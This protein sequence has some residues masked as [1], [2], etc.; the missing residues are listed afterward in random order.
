MCLFVQTKKAAWGLYVISSC[1]SCN[2]AVRFFCC[3]PW[4]TVYR[5]NNCVLFVLLTRSVNFQK[6]WR[7]FS[8]VVKAVIYGDPPHGG[9]FLRVLNWISRDVILSPTTW[10]AASCR[11]SSLQSG[12]TATC[13]VASYK[14]DVWKMDGVSLC[15]LWLKVNLE[16]YLFY[17][18]NCTFILQNCSKHRLSKVLHKIKC[19]K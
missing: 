9:T 11:L 13:G 14:I 10:T 19:N 12:I 18:S 5:S 17:F 1:S 16:L 4:N 8:V 7:G 15:S 3:S 2:V 6:E